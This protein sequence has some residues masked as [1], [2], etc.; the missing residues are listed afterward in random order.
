MK[1]DARYAVIRV[2]SIAV[3][4]GVDA[5]V[6][7]LQVKDPTR[8]PAHRF[9]YHQSVAD[10]PGCLGT[11]DNILITELNTKVRVDES[12]SVQAN[13]ECTFGIMS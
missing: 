3:G 2:D 6:S 11:V 5:S 8:Q 13:R 9:H 7:F 12:L 10:S 1:I 4:F